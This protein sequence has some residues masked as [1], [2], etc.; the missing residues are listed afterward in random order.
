MPIRSVPASRPK[1]SSAA[2]PIPSTSPPGPLQKTS[3]RAA[4]SRST[5]GS[6]TPAADRSPSPS[7]KR[8]KLAARSICSRSP[9]TRSRRAW[10]RS[11]KV[12]LKSTTATAD[13]ASDSRA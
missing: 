5:T 4:V 7:S 3:S 8:P 6:D 11:T 1:A 9:R 10:E 2:A 12:R 13:R